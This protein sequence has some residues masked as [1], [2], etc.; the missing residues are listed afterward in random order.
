M[1]LYLDF[2]T[3]PV[4]FAWIMMTAG[5]HGEPWIPWFDLHRSGSR[6]NVFD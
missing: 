6:A 1:L 4:N 3:A 5:G 2:I